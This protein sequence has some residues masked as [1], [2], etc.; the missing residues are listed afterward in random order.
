MLTNLVSNAVKFTP[1]GEVYLRV[2]CLQ[3]ERVEF[4][5]E[6]TGIGIASEALEQIFDPF[7]QADSGTTRLFGGTGLGLAICHNLVE[8][9][10]SELSVESAPGSGSTFR[11]D[12]ELPAAAPPSQ[13]AIPD[14]RNDNEAHDVSAKRY[15][16]LLVDDTATNRMITSKMLDRLGYAV[17]IGTN[18][19]EAV[20]KVREQSYDL[21][22][23]G[24]QHAGHGRL[25]GHP[26]DP[27]TGRTGGQPADRGADR[28]RPRG[29][30]RTVHR[31]RHG[32]LPR[33]AV[34]ARGSPRPVEE[35]PPQAR[36]RRLS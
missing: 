28:V 26:S 24:L 12:C 29:R 31:G 3:G 35:R 2:R 21:V 7:T 30:P 4:A 32:Q 33:E 25:P 5:I 10:G 15:R 19:Q 20:E 17:D 18:G 14:D 27:C 6:D 34:P 8:L 11:F 9:M 23:D 13:P 22:P 36:Q 16:V 1:Q